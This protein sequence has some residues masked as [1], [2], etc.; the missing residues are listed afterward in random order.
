MNKQIFK[1]RKVIGSLLLFLVITGSCFFL[2]LKPSQKSKE[3]EYLMG[4]AR[5]KSDFQLF[6]DKKQ[7]VLASTNKGSF[8][9]SKTYAITDEYKT[10]IVEKEGEIHE[11][12]HLQMEGEYW[13]LILY[14]LDE[15]GLPERKIDLFQAVRNYNPKG[16]PSSLV[17]SYYVEDTHYFGLKIVDL[18]DE[19]N[20]SYKT[21]YLNLETEEVVNLPKD[22]KFGMDDDIKNTASITNYSKVLSSLGYLRPANEIAK[23]KLEGSIPDPN[24]NLYSLY[25]DLEDKLINQNWSLYVRPDKVTPD[26]W[27]DTLLHW[28]APKGED[29]LTVYGRND[30]GKASDVQIRNSQE[31]NAWLEKHPALRNVDYYRADGSDKE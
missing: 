27:F 13:N 2:L 10:F 12:P 16:V 31:A 23:T 14:N 24:I 22:T 5:V 1:N 28:F 9:V 8:F 3:L 30:D 6:G 26:E 20:R 25:P 17:G 4:T 21:V 19:E 11:I 15:E 7:Y 29:I 18:T